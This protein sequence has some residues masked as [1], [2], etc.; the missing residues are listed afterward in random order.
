M[1]ARGQCPLSSRLV[2]EE[3]TEGGSGKES[4][5]NHLQITCLLSQQF[6]GAFVATEEEEIAGHLPG[7]CGHQTSIQP[8]NTI[9][10]DN[11]SCHLEGCDM[12]NDCWWHSAIS[13]RSLWIQLRNT[14]V[15]IEIHGLALSGIHLH[16]SQRLQFAFDKFRRAQSEW[17]EE[18]S[19]HTSHRVAIGRKSTV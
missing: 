14:N 6:S 2:C 17:W 11:L 4:S 9:I 18:C 12:F 3:T 15:W 13:G 5:H 16:F 8:K 7:K 10:L 1:C 19:H